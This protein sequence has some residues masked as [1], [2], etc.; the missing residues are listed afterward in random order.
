[1]QQKIK[2]C[3]FRLI[4]NQFVKL[5]DIMSYTQIT[6]EIIEKL[7]EENSNLLETLHKAQDNIKFLE[8]QLA[9]KDAL[10]KILNN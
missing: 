4:R 9:D 8:K 3:F 2:C 6:K 1:M 7:Q 10:I 5:L